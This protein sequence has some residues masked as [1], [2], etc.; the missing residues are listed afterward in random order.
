MSIGI[1]IRGQAPSASDRRR[2][3]RTFVRHA[4]EMTVAMLVGMIALGMAFRQI[5]IALF[6]TGFDDAW[7][8]HT[9]LAAFAM[10]FNMTLPMV[11]LMRYRGHSWARGGEMAAAM[12]LPAVPLLVLLWLGLISA[13]LVLPLQMALMLPSMILAMLYR[14]DEYAGHAHAPAVAMHTG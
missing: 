12:F 4:L 1:A 8:Q 13:H 6:G 10:A 7:H 11:A 3:R 5:H 14:A 9:E 2:P